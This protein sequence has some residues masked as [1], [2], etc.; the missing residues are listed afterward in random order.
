MAWLYPPSSTLMDSNTMHTY[1]CIQYCTAMKTQFSENKT[2]FQQQQ[3][4]KKTQE[5]RG[6]PPPG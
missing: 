2:L 4:K 6:V 5:Q 1:H 3:Q